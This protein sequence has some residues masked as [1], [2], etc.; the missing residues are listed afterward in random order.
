MKLSKK[1]IILTLIPLIALLIFATTM[2]H[3]R[4]K[5]FR[6]ANTMQLNIEMMQKTSALID[7]LQTEKI[8]Y[9]PLAGTH[10]E[11]DIPKADKDHFRKVI[12][13]FALVLE[14]S[15]I[16]PK[17]KVA[18]IRDIAELEKLEHAIGQKALS[19]SS[20][21]EKYDGIIS[22]LTRLGTA[23]TNANT[24]KGIGKV[25]NTMT[26]L[27][28]S[29]VSAAR[30]RDEMV[31]ILAE[32]VPLT[33]ERIFSLAKLG[34]GMDSNLSSALVLSPK[35]RDDLKKLRQ[36]KPWKNM[37]VLLAHVLKKAARGNYD[38]KPELAF[39]IGNALLKEIVLI[40]GNELELLRQR[41]LRIQS[42]AE[43]LIWVS[44]SALALLF[45][46][47]ACTFF[48]VI[49]SIV[50]PVGRIA[51]SLSKMVNQIMA[52]S[53]EVTS[54][55]L[56]IAESS[57]QQ[58]ACLEESSASF[59]KL[60]AMT[61][62]NAG[63]TVQ[64]NETMT[65]VVR[66]MN[67]AKTVVSG[68]GERMNTVFDTSRETQKVVHTIDEIAFQTNLLSLNASVEAASAGEAGAGFA[69]VAEEVRNLAIRAANA[70][71]NTAELIGHASEMV[72]DCSGMTERTNEAFIR[73]EAF[74][75]KVGD[76]M[77][78]IGRASQRQAEGVDQN[79]NALS[80]INRA[81]QQN[82]AETEAFAS[83]SEELT[84]HAAQINDFVNQLSVLVYGRHVS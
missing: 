62:Q 8:K 2:I 34:G 66:M 12:E 82:A 52:A 84:S 58:A 67:E 59:E 19:E 56:V 36:G 43:K 30:L 3:S 6:Y 35:S 60:F 73:V 50:R 33:D 64:V 9:L 71:K 57:S 16:S 1:L 20:I 32:N 54:A 22:S 72:R 47:M 13:E 69:V 23:A 21:L 42:D 55:S 76:L 4:F 7:I 44:L 38:K 10:Q 61:K 51:N 63:H 18:G 77:N 46:F 70:S 31:R 37:Y 14:K 45:A 65:E 68:L 75:R 17:A 48:F 49:R 81:T 28:R 79:N 41:T 53:E 5:D 24:A 11:K 78:E 74:T 40:T 80:E 29:K 27:E 39:D 83:T 15:R 25:M 26:I